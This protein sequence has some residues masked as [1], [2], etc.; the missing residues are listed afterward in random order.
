MRKFNHSFEPAGSGPRGTQVKLSAREIEDAGLYEVLQTPGAALGSWAILDALLDPASDQFVFREPLGQSRE[1]KT[2]LSGIFGRF[3][4]RA[5]LTRYLGYRYFAHITKPPMR[6][7]GVRRGKVVRLDLGDVPDWVAWK[8]RASEIAIVE[9]KGS[10]D[11][12]GLAKSLGRAWTQAHRVDIHINGRPAPLKR[13]AI[14]T[15]WSS[16]KSPNAP[17]IA[18]RDPDENR[19]ATPEERG[20]LGVGIARLHLASLLRPLGHPELANALAAAADAT[21]APIERIH[22][23][24]ARTALQTS[25]TRRPAGRA[26]ASI[27]PDELVGGF[28]TRAGPIPARI[29]I[30]SADRLALRRLALN[31]VFIG[32]ERRVLQAAIDGDAKILGQFDFDEFGDEPVAPD[33]GRR[34]RGQAGTWLIRPDD[35]DIDIE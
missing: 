4:A 9:A 7:D 22:I 10:H 12:S 5:Y 28:V 14:A 13:F 19:E 3:V 30:T 23:D 21:A 18:V 35:D 16:S 20:Q 1:V 17:T 33:D 27:I 34:R 26:A 24:R 15:W 25:P 11:P 29:E 6:I 2:A 32:V 31:P 8:A